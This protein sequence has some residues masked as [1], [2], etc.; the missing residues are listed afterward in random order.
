MKFSL[1]KSVE[2]LERTPAVL[3]S[4]LLGLSDDWVRNNEGENTW[5]PY[6]IV[7]HL[8]A[9]EKSDWITRTNIILGDSEPKIFE[10]FDRTIQFQ[11]DQT[12]PIAL[13]LDEFSSLRAQN[14][15]TL[16]S[17]QLMD[18]DL[19]KTGLHPAFGAVTL[20]NLLST[21]VVHDMGHLGQI[22]RVV[23]K[24]YKDEVGPWEQY[25]SVLSK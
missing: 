13:L 4:L 1:R 6:D 8:I 22:S 15:K 18:D 20:E 2:V 25:L 24:Q 17:M 14:L 12:R 10:P 11:E 23:A 3:K 16:N 19:H 9:G 21:W 7:G 5:S